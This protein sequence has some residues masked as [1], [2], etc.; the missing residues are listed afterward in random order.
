MEGFALALTIIGAAA[1][2]GWFMKF[3]DKLE[4]RK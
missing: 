2:T 4:G 1:V 3:L